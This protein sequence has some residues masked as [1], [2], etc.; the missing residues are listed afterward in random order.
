M[1]SVTQF[2]SGDGHALHDRGYPQP[3]AGGPG[4]RGQDPAGRSL[5]RAFGCDT[6]EGVARSRDH[7]LRLRSTGEIAAAFARCRDLRVRA[8]G[9]PRQHHRYAGVPGLPRP[10]AVGARSGRDRG[11]RR[12]RNQR[13]RADDA[14][15]DGFRES[16]RPSPPDRDQ[17][18]RQPRCP[19]GRGA[20]GDPRSLRQDLPAAQPAGRRRQGGGRLLLP[21]ARRA[22]GHRLG[23][24]GAHRDHRPGGRSRR[25]ADGALPRAGRG[26][27]PRAAPR[28]V[29]AGAARGSSRAGVLLLRGDRRRDRGIDRRAAATRCRTR[30]RATRRPFSRAKATTPSVSRCRRIRRSTSSATYS[31]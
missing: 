18:D 21:A 13:R 29:R 1:L 31:R 27:H 28:S 9:S 16:T 11:D 20:R 25:R 22:D 30:P 7:G 5:A 4:R 15:D 3:R 10:H 26:A 6:V 24:G 2:Q 8:A 19:H 17:Q 14:P 23:R 12:E